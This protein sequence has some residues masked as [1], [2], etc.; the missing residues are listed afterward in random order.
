MKITAWVIKATTESG[1]E[2]DIAEIPNWLA[3]NIDDWLTEL[4]EGEE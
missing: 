3:Q 2:I 4:E 1:E